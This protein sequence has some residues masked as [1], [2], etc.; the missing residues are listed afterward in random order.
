MNRSNR[1]ILV[2]DLFFLL[3]V[4]AFACEMN[5]EL[6]DSN[7]DSQIVVPGKTVDLALEE[8]YLLLVSF[9]ED[10]GRCAL[11]PEETEFLLHKEKWRSSLD[12]LPLQL[13]DPIEWADISDRRHDAELSFRAVQ[14]GKWELEVLRDCEKKG[15]Y[16]ECLIFSVS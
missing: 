2:A 11:A 6:I 13:L 4:D 10:R 9:I 3:S 14:S 12:H 1:A 15:G 7:G 8:T 16:D 5:F